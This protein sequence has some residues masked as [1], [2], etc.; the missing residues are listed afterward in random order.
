MRRAVVHVAFQFGM[1]V[2]VQDLPAVV[3]RVGQQIVLVRIPLAVIEPLF[4][5]GVVAFDHEPSAAVKR[6]L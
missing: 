4:A 3:L 2:L 6:F 1:L 5:V